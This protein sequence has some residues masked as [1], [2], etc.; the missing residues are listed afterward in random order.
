MLRGVEGFL[1]FYDTGVNS[2]NRAIFCGISEVPTSFLRLPE[3]GAVQK[4]PPEPDS[5]LLKPL[6]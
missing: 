6:R 2:E 1:W 4:I 3:V 5:A